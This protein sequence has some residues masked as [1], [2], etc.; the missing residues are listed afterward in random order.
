MEKTQK[1]IADEEINKQN[2]FIHEMN[3][4]NSGEHIKACVITFGCRQNEADSERLC[5]ILNSAGYEIADAE[6]AAECGVI[7]VNTCAIREH[8]ELKALSR[9]GQLKHI[10]EQNRNVIICICGCMAEQEHQREKIKKSY[11]FV[12]IIFGPH[13]IYKFPE[14]LYNAMTLHKKIY[15]FPEE[16]DKISEGLPVLRKS[17]Y[18]ADVSIM[19]GCN[20]FCSYCVVPYVRGRERSRDKNSILEEIRGLH[21]SGCVEFML[22]GQNVNSYG[23]KNP[24]GGEHYRFADLLNDILKINGEY[25]IRF[26][27]SHPKDVSDDLI[28]VISSDSRV[29][30]HFHLPLQSGSDRILQLMNRGYDIEKYMSIIAKLRS[31]A[32]EISITSDIIV[33]FPTETDAEFEKTISAVEKAKFDN[34]FP[35]IYSK[36]KNTPAAQMECALDKKTKNERF[37]RLMEVQKIISE[38]SNK[39]DAGKIFRTLVDTADG[40][41]KAGRTSQGKLVYIDRCG[42]DIGEFTNVRIKEAKLHALYGEEI[43]I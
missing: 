9:T 39:N 18:K 43:N 7:V 4:L 10:K 3:R 6:Y 30:R 37:D 26:M 40:E 41:V 38:E 14:M 27:T 34:I 16:K 25:L 8:A 2:D 42:A 19:Y 33:G 5:G 12:D 17:K 22:L 36:R 32:P 11:S 21:D 28:S 35:F 29:E 1:F 23:D 15:S 24:R 13:G 31:A 20:N